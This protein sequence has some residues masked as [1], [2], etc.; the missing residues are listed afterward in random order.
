VAPGLVAS[1]PEPE[2]AAHFAALPLTRDLPM[3]FGGLSSTGYGEPKLAWKVASYK[4]L[5]R[6]EIDQLGVNRLFMSHRLKSAGYSFERRQGV[7][8]VYSNPTPLP[9]AI[10]VSQLVSATDAEHALALAADPAFDPRV[11]AV[12]ELAVEPTPNA[13]QHASCDVKAQQ[14]SPTRI[15]L[16]SRSAR[17]TWLVLFD[18]WAPGWSAQVDGEAVSI[19]RANGMFRLL[20]IPAG[21]A[22]IEFEYWPPRFLL[23]SIVAFCGIVLWLALFVVARRQTHLESIAIDQTGLP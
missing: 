15:S 12:V 9:R 3:R 14:V 5:A 22:T 16:E 11:S 13:P 19:E 2:L 10:C 20:P 6:N 18:T 1:T 21:A 23:G 4:R 8:F 7:S 17:Q